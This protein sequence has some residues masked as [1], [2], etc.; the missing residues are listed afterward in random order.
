MD[1]KKYA[2]ACRGADAEFALKHPAFLKWW[3]RHPNHDESPRYAVP[4]RVAYTVAMWRDQ[5]DEFTRL[6]N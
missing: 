6:T 2:E 4:A 5:Y 1:D 3:A